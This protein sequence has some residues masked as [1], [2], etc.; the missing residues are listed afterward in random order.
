[1]MAF[2]LPDIIV[3]TIAVKGIVYASQLTSVFLL[4]ATTPFSGEPS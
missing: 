2:V 3:F 4:H 1:M